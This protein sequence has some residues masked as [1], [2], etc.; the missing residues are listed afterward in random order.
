ML[1]DI[2]DTG[3]WLVR[4]NRQD[5]ALKDDVGKKTDN[6]QEKYDKLATKVEIR[7]DRLQKALSKCQEFQTNFADFTKTVDDLEKR[8]DEEEPLN[9]RLEPLKK[10]K[11]EHEVKS[12]L[13]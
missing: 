12:C 10:Q 2:K 8:L 1:E 11:E 4:N 3:D 6:N 5:N 7:R 9:A 13:K